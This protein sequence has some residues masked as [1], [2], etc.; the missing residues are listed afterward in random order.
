L[1][2]AVVVSHCLCF[3]SPVGRR[4]QRQAAR[5][6]LWGGETRPA[7]PGCTAWEAVA[8]NLQGATANATHVVVLCRADGFRL[9]RPAP[10]LAA[11]DRLEPGRTYVL[12][13]ADRLPARGRGAVTAASPSALSYHGKGS[14]SSPSLAGGARSP[15]EY[16]K[17]G[18]DGRT[19]IKV[20]E[21]FVL[22]AVTAG[23]GSSSRQG[24][25]GRRSGRQ[26]IIYSTPELRRQYEQLVG[27]ARW[28]PRLE[29]IEER[30]ARP[31][32]VDIVGVSPRRLLS[33]VRLLRSM[34]HGRVT[35]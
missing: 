34:G 29:T 10:V 19:A 13:P 24:E 20:A 5:L 6:V 25:Y 22:K 23:R 17:D 2:A 7:E 3:V 15:F 11:S 26:L 30:K 8:S 12:L 16:V 18:V 35:E 28:S 4:R 9:G 31:R 21:E 1:I 33:P 14:S 32:V 27:A